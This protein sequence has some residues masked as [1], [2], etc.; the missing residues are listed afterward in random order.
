M[1]QVQEKTALNGDEAASAPSDPMDLDAAIDALNAKEADP[2]DD[3]AAA[4][5]QEAAGESANEDPAPS[6]EDAAK[7]PAAGDTPPAGSSQDDIWSSA[8]PALREAH[9]RAIRDERL[10]AE[11]IRGRQSAADRENAQLRKRLAE[12]DQGTGSGRKPEEE[13]EPG[14]DGTKPDRQ[15][16]LNDLR[17]EY[18]D[19]GGPILDEMADLR[20]RLGRL[21]EPVGAMQQR[22]QESALEQQAALV[23]EKH[24]D[25]VDIRTDE[26]LAG[27][28]QSQPRAVLE[29]MSRNGEHIVDGN[30]VAWVVDLFKRDMGIGSQSAPNPQP[31]P[32][33]QRR[34]RQKQAGRDAQGRSGPPVAT[35]IP[36]DDVDAAITYLDKMEGNA[37]TG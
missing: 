10:R 7:Q 8:D 36:K 24:P 19:L 16:I 31:Q 4:P 20:E 18:P 2:A 21:E 15:K 29:A 28:A 33:Q 1:S 9:E 14:A 22:D 12:L 3:A 11:G 5:K 27:W 26:R 23:L 35:G 17:E 6:L 37:A 13:Q 32:H 25:W 34:E 30:E